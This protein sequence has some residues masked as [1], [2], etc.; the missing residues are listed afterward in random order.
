MA[1]RSR[2]SRNSI[3][4]S[5]RNLILSVLGITAVL[6][7][8]LRYGIPLISDVSFFAGQAVPNKEDVKKSEDDKYVPSPSLD[9]IPS[10]TKEKNIKI[11]GTSLTGLTIALY[12]NGSKENEAEV[13]EDGTFEFDINLSEG[14]NIIKAKAINKDKNESDLSDAVVINF[15]KSSPNLTIDSPH[16]GDN[17]SGG[18]TITVSGKTD[19][20]N[21]V[22]VNE[23]QAIIDS[24]GNYSYGLTL[25]GGDNEIKV[26]SRDP[27]GNETEK[28]IHVNYSQ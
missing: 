11:T 10:A 19:P 21:T 8:L 6:F 16:G 4:K 13:T 1:R 17:I 23:F 3:K 24:S 28:S 25:K 22:L 12:L 14:E 2:L 5:Q 15:K 9:P 27:A 20:D 7:L 26:V 18:S